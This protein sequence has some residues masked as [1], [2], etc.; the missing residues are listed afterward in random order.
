MNL[1]IKTLLFA[2]MV[3]LLASF[4]TLAAPQKNLSKPKAAD[5]PSTRHVFDEDHIETLEQNPNGIFSHSENRYSDPNSVLYMK[6]TDYRLETAS[7][8]EDLR[9]AP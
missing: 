4:P 3:S 9:Y 6:R 8:L 2:V 7:L 5:R 1:Q